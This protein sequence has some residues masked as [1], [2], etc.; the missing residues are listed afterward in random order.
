MEKLHIFRIST[1]FR[2]RQLKNP[3]YSKI[4]PHKI[5]I[6][7]VSNCIPLSKY[8]KLIILANIITV[9]VNNITVSKMP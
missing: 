3:H 6:E 8:F 2:I 9:Q 7:H 1:E 4:R 5:K